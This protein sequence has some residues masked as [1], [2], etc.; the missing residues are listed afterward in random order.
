MDSS[1]ALDTPLPPPR[2]SREHFKQS[3]SSQDAGGAK[4]Q[5]IPILNR[6]SRTNSEILL[7]EDQ[8]FAEY[9]DNVMYNRVVTGIIRQQE[10]AI[11]TRPR[12]RSLDSYHHESQACISNILRTRHLDDASLHSQRRGSASIALENG[13]N[14]FLT[15]TGGFL[16][17]TMPPMDDDDQV[18]ALDL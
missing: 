8:A 3:A 12:S 5:S 11:A 15:Q 10:Q 1:F 4:T 17:P 14:H 9:K 7:S 13:D 2:S 18:F 6:I 16:A